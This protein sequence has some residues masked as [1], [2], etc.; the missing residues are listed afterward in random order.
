M[1]P[2]YF[3]ARHR[4]SAR[5]NYTENP[6]YTDDLHTVLFLAKEP[7]IYQEIE[8]LEWA[9]LTRDLDIQLHQAPKGG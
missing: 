9:L 7:H 5:Y 1:P 8:W 4:S 6:Y 3:A 2:S